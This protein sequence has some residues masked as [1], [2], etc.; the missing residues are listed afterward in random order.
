MTQSAMN[1]STVIRQTPVGDPAVRT[2]A[3]P[4][5]TNPA[6]DIFGGWLMVHGLGR[7]KC[8]CSIRPRSV[9]PLQSIVSLP[10]SVK[11][12]DRYRFGRTF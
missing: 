6:G 10:L 3:M 11:V 2:I 9:Q 5:D 4:L 1:D 8:C 7:R 12:G